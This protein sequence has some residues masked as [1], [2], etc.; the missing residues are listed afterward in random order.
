MAEVKHGKGKILEGVVLSA[1]M[2][3]TI[4]VSVVT[5]SSHGLYKKQI[6]HRRK[7]KVH[8]E[9]AQAKEGDCVKIISC[10]PLSRDKRFT[11]LEVVKKR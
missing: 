6:I 3:K 5:K 2:A 11:L 1:K 7:Y 10:R 8:D 9:A 4:V